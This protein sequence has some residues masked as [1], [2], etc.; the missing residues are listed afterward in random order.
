L[1]DLLRRAGETA[2]LENLVEARRWIRNSDYSGIQ[3][4]LSFFGHRDGFDEYGNTKIEKIGRGLNPPVSFA[5]YR[6]RLFKLAKEIKD[7]IE[8]TKPRRYLKKSRPL[9]K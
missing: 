2:W 1:I 4:L 8:P 6:H 3:Y 7:E 5:D 9:R